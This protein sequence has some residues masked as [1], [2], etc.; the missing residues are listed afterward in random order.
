MQV[1]QSLVPSGS[2]LTASSV[3]SSWVSLSDSQGTSMTRHRPDRP[4]G[5]AAWHRLGLSLLRVSISWASSSAIGNDLM[6]RITAEG[7]HYL[8]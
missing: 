1:A 6:V 7:W 4:V 3:T 2:S 8:V 5:Y